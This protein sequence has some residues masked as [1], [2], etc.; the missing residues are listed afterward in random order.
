M[1]LIKVG[2]W[3]YKRFREEQTMDVDGNLIAIVGPNEAGKTSLLEAL[4]DHLNE[5]EGGIPPERL[6]RNAE[7]REAQVWA[8]YV[9]DADDRR[10]LRRR[11]R[12]AREVRQTVVYKHSDG[13]FWHELDP[14]VHRDVRPRQRAL[15]SVERALSSKW[16][17]DTDDEEGSLH[18]LLTAA[19]DVLRLHGERLEPQLQPLRDLRARLAEQSLPASLA[20]LPEHL[21]TAAEKESEV[22]P[23]DAAGSVLEARRPRFRFFK[24]EAR[25][26]HSSY[27][28]DEPPNQAL[29]NFLALARTSWSEISEA[30][31]DEGRLQAISERTA[32]DLDKAFAG[33]RQAHRRVRLRISDRT[34]KILVGLQDE[35]DYLDV[36]RRSDGLQQFIALRAYVQMQGDITP[37]ILLIDEAET[38][39]H[40]DAQADLVEVLSEQQDASK[41]IY[42]THSAGCL[43]F[44]LGT[45]VRI[46]LPKWEETD[47]GTRLRETDVSEIIDRFWNAPSRGA[48]FKPL[49]LGMGATTFA[50]AS[51]RKAIIAE[52]ASDAIL[53]P[54]LFREVTGKSALEFQVAPNLAHVTK[55]VVDELDL[56]AGRVAY[57][58]DADQGGRDRR[59]QLRRAGIPASRILGLSEGKRDLTLE[60]LIEAE[61]YRAAVNAVLSDWTDLEVPLEAIPASKRHQ[62]VEVWCA[63]QRGNLQAPA[64]PAIAHAVVEQRHDTT[65]V[66]AN[67]RQ[68][69]IALHRQITKLLD[70]PTHKTI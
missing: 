11:V 4:V 39:L 44:D 12:E 18:G 16:L 30:H 2:L 67:R 55:E 65:L 5:P 56:V 38:H 66:A 70:E 32:T 10:I 28:L 64:K 35:H 37:P 26:L 54:T 48:G 33:W 61:V 29:H 20:R 17:R 47:E 63:R 24:G 62:A 60:D 57:V 58:V 68:G 43:P 27:S 3:G 6:T 21:E 13:S 36:E 9:L 46:I 1:R 69:L 41:V 40:Y 51:T 19:R 23:A 31:P 15:K 52:G 49:L 14:E 45:G 53:L 22:H 25:D 59:R 50:F 34:V 42:T 8:R 7:P